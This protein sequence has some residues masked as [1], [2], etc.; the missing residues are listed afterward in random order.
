MQECGDESEIYNYQQIRLSN[1]KLI[2]GT[3]GGTL[4]L[5]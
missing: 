3:L 2:N 5:A 1:N 4:D